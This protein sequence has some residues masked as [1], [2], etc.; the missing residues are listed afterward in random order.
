MFYFYQIVQNCLIP[1]HHPS[2]LF[3]IVF[4]ITFYDAKGGWFFVVKMGWLVW[5]HLGVNLCSIWVSY[6]PPDK[7]S[8][9]D[10]GE[11]T[12]PVILY[13]LQIQPQTYTHTHIHKYTHTHTHIYTQKH[14]SEYKHRSNKKLLRS[15]RLHSYRLVICLFIAPWVTRFVDGS[16]THKV[17]YWNTSLLSQV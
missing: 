1:I 10:E 17:R 13:T 8:A 15:H 5:E 14:T 2:T 3:C 11:A 6:Y 12:Q 16:M 4:C 9:H 7:H